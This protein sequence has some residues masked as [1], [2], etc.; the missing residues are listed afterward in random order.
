MEEYLDGSTGS[1]YQL[2]GRSTGC[3]NVLFLDAKN[4]CLPMIASSV[5]VTGTH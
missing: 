4:G 2:S 5:R 3:V 1:F